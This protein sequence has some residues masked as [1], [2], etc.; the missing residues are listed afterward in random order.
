MAEI[1]KV[2]AIVNEKGGVGKSTLTVNLAVAIAHIIRKLRAVEAP[3]LIVDNDPQAGAS[4]SVG[5]E[6]VASEASLYKVYESNATSIGRRA[7]SVMDVTVHIER[8]GVS[9]AP[10]HISMSMLELTIGSAVSREGL[11]K[12]ALT[13][14]R[15]QYPITLID[16]APSLGLLTLNALTAADS[17]LI[18]VQTSMLA[19]KGL[20]YLM[21]TVSM[22]KRKL[23][24]GLQIIGV[25]P[26]FVDNQ[27]VSTAA[28]AYLRGSALVEEYPELKGKVMDSV[29]RR[30]AVYG[31]VQ[32]EAASV[33][34][35][36][37]TRE[38]G[39][40]ELTEAQAECDQIAREV[41]E[42]CRV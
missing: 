42:R 31:K 24:P 14:V 6:D 18:P 40:D 33:Y 32:V 34:A 2:I 3:V 36:T 35:A 16:C 29:M 7:K 9:L 38:V 4:V 20:T 30:R 10:A 5:V 11:L 8:E 28:L 23:N 26:T 17:V 22:V 21:D 12:E 27:R 39:L 15:R 1:G 13:Q 37:S 41:L 19:I 25:L